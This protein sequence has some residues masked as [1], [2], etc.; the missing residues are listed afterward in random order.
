MILRVCGILGEV[1]QKYV[2]SESIIRKLRKGYYCEKE[3]NLLQFLVSPGDI[4]LDVGANCGQWTYWLSKQVGFFGKVIAIEPMP[5]TARILQR[6]IDR[7]RLTNVI[8]QRVAV[9]DKN[10]EIKMVI[11][12][13]KN[14]LKIISKAHVSHHHD[15]PGLHVKVNMRTL[16]ELM[17]LLSIN[18][19]NFIKCDIEGAEMQFFQG[20]IKTLIKDKPI[21]ICEIEQ[22]HTSQFGYTPEDLFSFLQSIGYQAFTY[23]FN[24]LVHKSN[25]SFSEI[26]YVFLH[27]NAQHKKELLIKMGKM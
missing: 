27:E 9:G 5:I 13:D 11:T 10:C 23:S 18:S 21:I 14:R 6:T 26:N 17:D 22:R 20:G 7:F 12:E 16:T 1:A 8:V 25:K 24:K 2:E 15:I 3:I 19:V 4:C